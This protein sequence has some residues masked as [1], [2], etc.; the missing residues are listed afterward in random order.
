GNGIKRTILSGAAPRGAAPTDR[1][2]PGTSPA[3]RGLWRG[4]VAGNSSSAVPAE[5]LRFTGRALRQHDIDQRRAAVVHRLVEGAADV[6]RVLDK[7]A[8]AAKGF[9]DAV[10]AGTIDQRVWLHVEHRIFWD[11]RHAGTDAA[12]VE[13]DDLDR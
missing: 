1:G 13:H 12:I 11:L 3:L 4:L 10:I 7:E 5:L 8:L 9:H 2:R 6:L